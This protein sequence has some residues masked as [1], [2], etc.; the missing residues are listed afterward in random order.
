MLPTKRK[1]LR[2][3]LNPPKFNQKRSISQKSE[4]GALAFSPYNIVEEGL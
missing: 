4:L 3:K 2:W 1:K